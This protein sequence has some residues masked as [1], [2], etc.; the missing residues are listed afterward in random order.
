MRVGNEKGRRRK[1]LTFGIVLK[2]K[3]SGN[4]QKKEQ[5]A[6]RYTRESNVK[7]NECGFEGSEFG[8]FSGK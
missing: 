2:E 8:L 7:W 1:E 6:G 4:P 3:A 5:D